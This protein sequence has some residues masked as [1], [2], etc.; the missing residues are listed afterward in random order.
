MLTPFEKFT[1]RL[2]PVW[3]KKRV[4]ARM[5]L[6]AYEAAQVGR[7]TQNWNRNYG[8]VNTVTARSLVELRLHARDLVRNNAHA[9]RA[10]EVITSNTVGWGLK[11]Q[12]SDASAAERWKAWSESTECDAEGKLT[13]AGLQELVLRTVVESGEC[14]V[15]RRYR[16]AEDELAIPL[17]LQVMEPDFLDT[18]KDGE[19]G[20]SGGPI[21]QGVEF[22]K[23]GRRVAY[24]LF[25]AHPG[26]NLAS[27]NPS[28]RYPAEDFIHVFRALR[29]GQVRGVTWM[30]QSITPLK[31]FDAFEDA[32]L[33]SQKIASCF[34]VFVQDDGQS[35]LPGEADADDGDLSHIGPG[36]VHRLAPGK[37]VAFGT[38]PAVTS[39]NFSSRTLRRIASGLGITYED[40]TG[41]YSGVNF[42]SARMG[43]LSHWGNV[44]KWRWNMLVPQ[45]CDTVFS[46]AMA[47]AFMESE[48]T[49]VGSPMPMLEPDKEGLALNRLVRSGV[50][51]HDQMIL[52]Q[53]GDPKTHWDDYAAGIKKLKA[54]GIMLDSDASAVSQAGLTQERVGFGKKGGA[55]GGEEE[56]KEASKESERALELLESEIDQ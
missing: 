30:A 8:D 40:L 54:L 42:S 53:G 5:H 41:D 46:W 18:Q 10:V 22:N 17:Q 36:M 20:P 33:M 27:G 3:T 45:L 7:R 56:G 25:D 32:V 50:L 52:E 9:A 34:S 28:K 43:R 39:D 12:A 15:R 2:A 4:L 6:R 35:G 23:L 37:T 51:T 19:T 38:P 24:W 16:R 55:E 26:S 1:K 14:I 44:V 29:P 13:F 31:D 11:A 48:V 21:I 49:W 47:A